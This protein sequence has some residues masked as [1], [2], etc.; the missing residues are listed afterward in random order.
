MSRIDSGP[1]SFKSRTY[2]NRDLLDLMREAPTC[3]GCLRANDGT[4]VGAHKNEGKGM[5]IKQSDATACALCHGCHM[6]YDQGRGMS[7]DQRRAFFYEAHSRT[8]VWLIES[9]HLMLA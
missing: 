6:A 2:R 9:G 1:A 3:M 7:R 8:I 5:G 4:V